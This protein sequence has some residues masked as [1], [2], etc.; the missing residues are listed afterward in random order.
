M[1]GLAPGGTYEFSLRAETGGGAGAAA[2]LTQHMG[3]GA[4]PRPAA[5]ALPAAAQATPTTV[6]VRFRSDYFSSANGN[7]TA[8][9]LVLAEEPAAAPS[10]PA[11]RMP[12]WHDVQRLSV[13]PPYQVGH[14]ASHTIT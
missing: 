1:S 11:T 6:A 10:P 7:V 8:Y 2:R 14:L 5:S 12:S 4:P 3:I 9:T 13:W